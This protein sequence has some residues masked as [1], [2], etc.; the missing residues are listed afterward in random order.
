MLHGTPG[1]LIGEK[2]QSLNRYSIGIEISN[3]GHDHR[4]KKFSSN[5]FV[6]LS[7]Y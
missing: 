3:P 4:Y 5:K 6:L 1:S 7:N 2:F